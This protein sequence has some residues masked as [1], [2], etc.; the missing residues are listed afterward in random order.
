MEI[1]IK[2]EK[3]ICSIKNHIIERK[4]I[5]IYNADDEYWERYREKHVCPRCKIYQRWEEEKQLCK[6]C[7]KFYHR[8]DHE[9]CYD[10]YKSR[11][12]RY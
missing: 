7:G 3:D 12:K 6:V 11:Y 5:E 9:M 8:K 10:C 2:K 1:P 4:N